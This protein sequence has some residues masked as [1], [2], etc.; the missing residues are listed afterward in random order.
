[1]LYTSFLS[2]CSN[3]YPSIADDLPPKPPR[4]IWSSVSFIDLLCKLRIFQ[5]S[6]FLRLSFPS[7]RHQIFRFTPGELFIWD[8]I[9]VRSSVNI[10]RYPSLLMY[11]SCRATGCCFESVAINISFH[12]LTCS[13][14][15]LLSFDC[16]IEVSLDPWGSL[17]WSIIDIQLVE[18]NDSRIILPFFLLACVEL[19][20][21]YTLA[22]EHTRAKPATSESW[23]LRSSSSFLY[24]VE[25]LILIHS[26]SL[27]SIS[28]TL[29]HIFFAAIALSLSL[30]FLLSS[31]PSWR[32]IRTRTCRHV[33][34]RLGCGSGCRSASDLNW[35]RAGYGWPTQNPLTVSR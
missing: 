10:Y 31:L 1:M 23:F 4:K 6:C 28:S 9:F 5:G 35:F 29:I 27:L 21:L 11:R 15:F 19:T 24:F 30:F 3:D 26:S 25:F 13:S 7:S 32:W 12:R 33:A 17:T 34:T 16:S 22:F 8:Q 14:R 2:R 18:S 20:N